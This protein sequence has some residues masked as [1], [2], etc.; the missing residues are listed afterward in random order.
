MNAETRFAATCIVNRT[1][2]ITVGF[3]W[4]Y[5]VPQNQWKS[6]RITPKERQCFWHEYP[7]VK[8]N[9]SPDLLIY[10]DANAGVG[11][12]K[13]ESRLQSDP[14]PDKDFRNGRP[15]M[16]IEDGNGYIDLREAV[17]YQ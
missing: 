14:S 2:T 17:Y 5:D 8:Q 12:Q 16:F 9:R 13:R 3:S 11:K 7:D 6:D 1:S 4:K 10:F 15:Y